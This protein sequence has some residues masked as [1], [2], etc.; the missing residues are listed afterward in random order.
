MAIAKNAAATRMFHTG[1]IIY[2]SK[3]GVTTVFDSSGKQLFATDDAKAATLSNG[4][5]ATYVDEIPSGSME[6]EY[7]GKTYVT[8]GGK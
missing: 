1:A 4:V 8:Y 3:T 6:L 2:H 7:Q 5:L